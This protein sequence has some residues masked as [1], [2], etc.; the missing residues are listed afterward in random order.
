MDTGTENFKLAG[1][2][3]RDL[4][5]KTIPLSFNVQIIWT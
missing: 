5:T 2:F 4:A 1:N 3:H